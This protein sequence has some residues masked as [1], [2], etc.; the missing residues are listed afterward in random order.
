MS[1]RAP[2]PQQ[3]KRAEEDVDA[4]IAEKGVRLS[5]HERQALVEERAR[6]LAAADNDSP[7]R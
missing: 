6:A 2:S 7:P 1:T 5:T 3:I 4:E